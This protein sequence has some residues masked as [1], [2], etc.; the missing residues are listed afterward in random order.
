LEF[1]KHKYKSKG[2]LWFEWKKAWAEL[3][4]I[5]EP[6]NGVPSRFRGKQ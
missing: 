4:I 1:S 2:Y 3:G 6:G 5:A